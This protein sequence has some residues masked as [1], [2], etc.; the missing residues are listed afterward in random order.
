[1]IHDRR[2]AALDEPGIVD[3]F[4]ILAAVP[5]P[6]LVVGPSESIEYIN[7]AAEQFF[8]A[9]AGVLV[10]QGITAVAPRDGTLLGLMK[11]ARASGSSVAEHDAELYTPRMGRRDVSFQLTPLPDAPG[12]LL[13]T[14]RELTM[15]SRMGHQ[16]S[17]RDVARSVTGM[18]A[19]LAHEVKNPLAGIRGAAQL[20]EM[21][22]STEDRELTSLIRDETDRICSLIDSMEGFS[23]PRPLE[24]QP[25]NVHL[26][27]D[28]ARRVAQAGFAADTAFE[29]RYDPSLPPLLGNRDQ[30][31]QVVLNLIKNAV[32]ACS[33]LPCEIQLSTAY[34]HGLRLAVPGTQEQVHLPLEVAIQDNGPGISDDIRRHMFDP[35]VTTKRSGTG[36]GLSLVAKIIGDHSGLIECESEPGRTVFRLRLPIAANEERSSS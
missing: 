32:E 19:V 16:L 7:P 22:A 12:S 23:D 36:L 11:K 18:A 15:A 6:L 24:R 30:L 4:A 14:I 17:H 20:L 31:V 9:S 28:H 27:L 2:S 29:E 34:R 33:G 35:F 8:G 1:M 21:N 13:L 10:G 5:D 26:V 25:V 3:A